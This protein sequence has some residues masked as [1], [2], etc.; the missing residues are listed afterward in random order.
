MTFDLSRWIRTSRRARQQAY[1]MILGSLRGYGCGS[2]FA[3]D[4]VSPERK[5]ELRGLLRAI[6]LEVRAKY[7]AEQE[8]FHSR[9]PTHPSKTVWERQE[10]GAL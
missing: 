9:H 8:E 2:I 5:T 4:L 7:L 10:E 6:E 1:R 3:S